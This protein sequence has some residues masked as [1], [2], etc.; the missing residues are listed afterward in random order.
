MKHIL[1]LCCIVL[2]ATSGCNDSTNSN[3]NN[4]N[5]N[6]SKKGA[7]RGVIRDALSSAIVTS[8]LV[9]TEPATEDILTASD[10]S[11]ILV[12]DSGTYQV[13]VTKSGYLPYAKTVT[14][15]ANDTTRLD[16][17]LYNTSSN[18]PPST[19]QLKTPLQSAVLR[20]TTGNTFTWTCS[21]N[22][23]DALTY[24][25]YFGE[26]DQL[27]LISANIASVSHPVPQ[28]KNKTSYQWRIAAR[29]SKG[30]ITK[31][32]IG[33]FSVD[34]INTGGVNTDGLV[35]FYPLD[36]NAEDKSGNNLNGSADAITYTT[37]IDGKPNSCAVFDGKGSVEG[38]DSPL[39]DFDSTFTFSFWINPSA[40]GEGNGYKGGRII[41]AKST[42]WQYEKDYDSFVF[43]ILK[44]SSVMCGLIGTELYPYISTDPK[45]ILLNQWTHICFVRTISSKTNLY[46]N[47]TLSLLSP[48]SILQ[49]KSKSR[50]TLGR[51]AN[52]SNTTQNYIGLL[53]N[54]RIYNR[55][56][57]EDEVKNLYN[58]KQ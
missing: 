36:G 7:I 45:N 32:A 56:L 13:S 6:T 42:S 47:G 23:G 48:Y 58:T 38:V 39:Y 31:S 12:A 51:F 24:D 5:T 9:N 33:S 10:G 50:L 11:Y 14:I 54:I 16:I 52:V 20:N 1:L 34:S 18:T 29:D 44:D 8:A 3:G 15:R 26:T 17:L 22:D 57:T 41:F 4:N 43:S 46:I 2:V 30:S 55:A 19:P 53:D 35:A 40:Y 28:L 49:N 37:G 25:V 27:K 21:D